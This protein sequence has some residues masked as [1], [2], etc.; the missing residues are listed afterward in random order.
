[1]F[2]SMAYPGMATA[3]ILRSPS[4]LTW[5][6]STAVA[7]ALV[8]RAVGPEVLSVHTDLRSCWCNLR[9]SSGENNETEQTTRN[10]GGRV[11]ARSPSPVPDSVCDYRRGGH[12][13]HPHFIEQC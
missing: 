1:M 7:R 6:G 12:R 4:T 2:S 3:V 10:S 13:P 8:A 11:S 5:S 9:R